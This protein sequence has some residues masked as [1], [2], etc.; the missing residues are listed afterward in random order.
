MARP[1][2]LIPPKKLREGFISGRCSVCRR[3]FEM[4]IR[5]SEDQSRD[6]LQAIFDHHVCDDGFT[7]GNKRS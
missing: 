5:E 3:P 2:K 7:Q 1:R 4:P 6:S